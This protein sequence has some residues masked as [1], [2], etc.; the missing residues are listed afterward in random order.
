ME[1]YC[2]SFNE[3]QKKTI[4]WNKYHCDA[5]T[6]TP[7]QYLNHLINQSFQKVNIIFI[8]FGGYFFPKMNIKDYNVMINERTFFGQSVILGCAA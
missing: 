4:N 1:N 2:N 8:L 5:T 3:V 7:N 6:E